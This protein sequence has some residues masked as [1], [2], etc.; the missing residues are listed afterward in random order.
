MKS[1][2]TA[3]PGCAHEFDPAHALVGD[4]P[5]T[6]LCPAC[7][8]PVKSGPSVPGAALCFECGTEI[9]KPETGM[10]AI[11]DDCRPAWQGARRR[12]GEITD[13]DFAVSS[14]EELDLSPP[15]TGGFSFALTGPDSSGLALDKQASGEQ[16]TLVREELDLMPSS[17]VPAVGEGK[18]ADGAHPVDTRSSDHH[19][20]ELALRS[21]ETMADV[22]PAPLPKAGRDR[23]APP[24]VQRGLEA[25]RG[26][27]QTFAAAPTSQRSNV[28]QMEEAVPSPGSAPSAASRVPSSRLGEPS[29]SLGSPPASSPAGSR[30]SSPSGFAHSG[31][32]SMAFKKKRPVKNFVLGLLRAFG[33]LVVLGLGIAGAWWGAQQDALV[34]PEALVERWVG[35]AEGYRDQYL[36][37]TVDV[38]VEQVP[39][40][41]NDLLERLRE[42]HGTEWDGLGAARAM[43]EA[44]SGRT[45]LL[46]TGPAVL[47]RARERLERAVLM[48]PRCV[49]ALTGLAEAYARLGASSTEGAEA[50]VQVLPLLNQADRLGSYPVERQRARA[51]WLIYGGEGSSAKRIVQEALSEA[52]EDAHLHFLK[53]LASVA[54]D[55][56]GARAIE[57]FQTSLLH[58]PETEGVLLALGE[59]QQARG[60]YGP[61]AESYRLELA[62]SSVTHLL[63]RKLGLLLEHVG[64]FEDA[65]EHYRRSVAL[66]AL[67]PELALRYCANA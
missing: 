37:P 31:P 28:E 17:G 56:A 18:L 25:R 40:E 19:S 4:R 36:A 5:G 21:M 15:S 12:G 34:V 11:C 65:A 62:R 52:P 2:K 41:F 46:G 53:G 14:R 44:L 50:I 51:A 10:V 22:V 47:R 26:D 7:F 1:V 42:Q 61:A 20:M 39:R 45:L 66:N 33:V 30:L 32:E 8:E 9:S 60:E 64:K 63:H 38:P 43:E 49:L 57:A 13:A 58:E 29:A 54:D 48:E 24:E 16:P 67:Q 55:D 27:A 3:C 23:V 35:I 6:V 59:V